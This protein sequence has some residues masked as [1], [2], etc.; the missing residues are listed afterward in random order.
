[1]KAFYTAGV[2]YDVLLVF[3]ELSEEATGQRKYSKFKA[4]YIHNC[5]KTGETPI[6]GPIDEDGNAD[7]S[8]ADGGGGSDSNATVGGE[9]SHDENAAAPSNEP[10][11][12]DENAENEPEDKPIIDFKPH[13]T[14]INGNQTF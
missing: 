9:T 3:G 4:A 5:L 13:P 10:S 12:T 8:N 7:N 6:P 1:M 11:P 14:E 2:I